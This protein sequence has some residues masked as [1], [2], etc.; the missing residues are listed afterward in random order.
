MKYN[1]DE[2][3]DRSKTN[4]KKWNPSFYS[5]IYNGH[6]NLLPLW[7]ADMDFRVAKPIL[8][9]MQE[10]I[11]QGVLGYTVPDDE[12][13]EAIIAWNRRRKNIE[14]EKEWIVYTNGV[15]PAISFMIQTFTKEGD[16][17]IIQTP[18]YNPFR[19]ATE[20]NKRKVVTSSLINRD[21]RYEIDFKD[22][23]EKIVKN[24]VKL[25][26][27]CNPHNPVGRVWS[28]EELIKLGDICLKHNVLI[29]S[30]EI[31]S[32]LIYKDTQYF[33]FLN[34]DKKYHSNLLVC[35]APSKTFN[36]AGV[37][38]SLSIIPN[39]KLRELYQK[40]LTNL[41]IEV[42]NT[43]GIAGVKAGYSY[44]EEWL[45][46]LIEYLDENRKFISKFIS[47][48]MPKV[49]YREPEGT[50]LAWLY[51]GDVLNGKKIEEFFEKEAKVAIDY[52][53]WFGIEGE[54][55]IRLNFACPKSILKDAL[56][57]I[58]NSI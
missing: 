41:R 4:S 57:R 42:P 8:D 37:Q 39:R 49:K 47:E 54:G 2:V 52:G 28:K 38:T 11:E 34:L 18:V 35:T 31:H 22:F 1:F 23:E 25:F 5:D 12:Y 48:N 46:Q 7:V 32:D 33:S 55:Y 13:F 30:D 43:F 6:K 20:N 27:L 50:Y 3:I 29:V 10:I 24:E 40:T 16:G 56:E 15:V 53:Y 14:L 17:V 51:F 26:I 21:G 19:M 36:I 9:S 45:E 58:A 44:G